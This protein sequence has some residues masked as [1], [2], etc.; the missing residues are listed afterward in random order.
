[1][2]RNLSSN[3]NKFFYLRI[4][5]L[6]PHFRDISNSKNLIKHSIYIRFFWSVEQPNA[7]MD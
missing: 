1:M 2:V 4:F 5:P 3:L 6:P 7:L